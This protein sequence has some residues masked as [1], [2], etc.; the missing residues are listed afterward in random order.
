MKQ[1]INKILLQQV[2][3]LLGLLFT[4]A[5]TFQ[6]ASAQ[7]FQNGDVFVAVSNGQVQWRSSA[8]V[9]K[10]TLNTGQGGFTTG[11]A[12]D[13]ANNLYVTNFSASSVS[14][15]N[16]SGVSQ[17]L[18]GSGNSTP[19]SI[20]FDLAGNV[21]VGNI[22][23]GIR[24]YNSA[25]TFLGTSFTGRVDFMDLAADQCTMLYTTESS[26]IGR[27]NVCTNV[28]GTNLAIALGGSAFALRIRLNG[29]VLVANGV[30]IRR[31]S[32]A[33]AVLQTYDVAGAD[34]WFALNLNPDGTS[35]WSADINT[36]NVYKIDI[37]TGNVLTTFNT[38]T[39]ASTVFGLAVFGEVT[40]SVCADNVAPSF[41]PSSQACGTTIQATVGTPLS[42]TVA[43]SDA[44]ATDVVT[45]NTTGLP[46]GATMTPALSTSGN[47]VSSLFSWT[48]TA[49][50]LGSNA[51]TFSATDKCGVQVLCAYTINVTGGGG[52]VS[53]YYSKST[54]DLHNVLSWGVN[55]DGSGATP[56][57]FG[58]GKT[59]H[60]V[61]RVPTYNMNSDWTVGGR[62]DIPAG[63]QLRINGYTLSEADLIGTGS[64][65][66]SPTSNLIVTGI[67]GGDAGPL[68]FANGGTSLNN[69][70]LNRTGAAASATV[71]TSLG[72]YGVLTLTNGL[73]NTGNNITLVSNAANTARVAPITGSVSGNVTVERYVPA[74]RAWRIMGAPVGGNQTINQA[75]QEGA[76]TS[77]A[78]PNPNPGFGTHITE[79]LA[80]GFD[81]NPLVAM[82]SIKKY[83]SATDSWVPL[84]NTTATNVNS[85][86]YLLFVRGERSVALGYNTVTPTN[87]VLRATG[88]L[89]T[90]DQAFPVSAAGFTAIPNPFASPIDFATLT[91]NNVQN[92]FYLWDPKLGGQFGVG[93]YVLLSFNG[94]GYD[95]TPAAVSPESQYIQSGQGFLVHS[96]GSAGNLVIKESDKSATAATNVFRSTNNTSP[97]VTSNTSTKGLR[98]TLL[99]VNKDNSTAVLDESLTSYS[100]YFSNKVDQMDA[101]K[102]PNIEENI[103]LSRDGES[104]M[105]ERRQENTLQDTIHLKLWNTLA[106][107][108]ALH[109]SPVNLSASNIISGSLID[110][111]LHTTTAV[112]LSEVTKINFTVDGNAGSANPDRFKVVLKFIKKTLPAGFTNGTFK[113]SPNPITGNT[114]NIQF[115]DQPKGN[116]NVELVNNLGQ[117]I[118]QAR[119]KHAGGSAMQTLQLSRNNIVKGEVYRMRV[120]NEQ[121]NT[122]FAVPVVSN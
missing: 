47:P 94:S 115:V 48:P 27:H 120:R 91:K 43:A 97:A 108:Y 111:Y 73:L 77:S 116:Y 98:A 17:G 95:I 90:G 41:A 59:F 103:G 69:L 22:G 92:N 32:A 79:G 85:D 65:F 88:P 18:F 66:G 8:G 11:M 117:L 34:S 3:V 82:K 57:D 46:A 50:N 106:K 78:N 10:Q 71:G 109:F 112:S 40:V 101:I 63:S 83:I 38:G 55:M 42:F 114:I 28:A 4:L 14:R 30:N 64:L 12:F 45:L 70:S 107:D 25:G 60:L 84:A 93:G 5:I 110:N 2:P 87:T 89:K 102:M 119:V 16:S 67:T 61:N 36:A 58:T 72:I 96:T 19:E 100:P 26:F 81:H 15:F 9:L 51:V 99:V 121:A 68:N 53:D 7:T 31:L 33:G 13:A 74:R 6:N 23:N 24:K 75:W 105:I 29:E 118:Y 80:D 86:A 49:A 37:A 62:L 54:G 56:P 35:F 122:I 1:F 39:G 20:V 44:N 104:L 21:Y 76:T 113:I 52:S